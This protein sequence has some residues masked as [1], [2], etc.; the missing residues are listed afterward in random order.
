MRVRHI[1]L[2]RI[3]PGILPPP[4]EP[5]NAKETIHFMEIYQS[6]DPAIVSD[7]GLELLTR[8]LWMYSGIDIGETYEYK[9]KRLPNP[10]FPFDKSVKMVQD[11]ISV[12]DVRIPEYEEGWRSGYSTYY[13][14]ARDS[15]DTGIRFKIL[16]RFLKEKE[17]NITR[18][19]IEEQK[20]A[21]AQYER[22]WDHGA[23]AALSD[24]E[25]E[26]KENIIERQKQKIIQIDKIRDYLYHNDKSLDAVS[27]AVQLNSEEIWNK[28]IDLC[29]DIRVSADD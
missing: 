7:Y 25:I 14:K 13:Q 23:Y 10:P 27:R 15:L 29:N 5:E 8:D 12:A 18:E 19:Q 11:S 16:L 28:I 3:V 20:R 9:G 26:K 21:Y 6:F 22:A 24:E 17:P 1:S 4:K 2:N